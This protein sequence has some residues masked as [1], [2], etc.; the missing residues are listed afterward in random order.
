[1]PC[2]QKIFVKVKWIWIAA[3]LSILLLGLGAYRIEPSDT[4]TELEL[5]PFML[6]LSFPLGILPFVFINLYLDSDP[7]VRYSLFWLFMFGVGYFQ[8]FVLVPSLGKSR[9]ISLG[10]LE[11]STRSSDPLIISRPNTRPRRQHIRSI[12]A[13]DK[14]GLSPL[15][16]AINK[17]GQRP[18]S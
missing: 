12:S 1:M 10:L 9:I 5:L 18:A 16:R 2:E 4:A 17:N 7:P 6:G 8:W 3:C 15:Q 11:S 13:F 14:N